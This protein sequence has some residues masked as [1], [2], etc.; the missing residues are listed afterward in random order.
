MVRDLTAVTAEETIEN[1]LK[2][3]S[4]QLLSGVPVVSEDMRVV[5]FVGEEDIVKAIV[6]GYFS[7]L[8][9]TVFLPDMNQLFRNLNLIKDKP[10]SQLMKSPALVVNENASI[11]HVAD[12]MIR[13]NMKV[14]AVVD[15]QNRLVG[16]VSRTNILMAILEGNLTK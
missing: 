1:V 7:L 9:S 16:V 14:L 12:L 4:T 15:D 13:S 8:E 2:I 3:M 6:P 10:V 11:T 5:G